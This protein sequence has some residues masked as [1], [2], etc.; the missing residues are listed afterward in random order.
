MLTWDH[1][2]VDVGRALAVSHSDTAESILRRVEIALRTPRQADQHAE[3][4]RHLGPPLD[5]AVVDSIEESLRNCFPDRAGYLVRKVRQALVGSPAVGRRSPFH[6]RELIPDDAWT[7]LCPALT[8]VWPRNDEDVMQLVGDADSPGRRFTTLGRFALEN[9]ETVL[10]RSSDCHIVIREEGVS[11]AHLEVN[12]DAGAATICD[13]RSRNGTHLLR[14]GAD[15]SRRRGVIQPLTDV[16][17]VHGDC[18][19]V[20]GV[21]L[22]FSNPSQD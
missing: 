3:T 22:F 18:I 12:I 8:V 1:V 2:L 10:G 11:R 4:S 15:G 20:G 17:L 19:G 6:G 16:P 7:A 5:P 21:W 13:L 14:R 9:V